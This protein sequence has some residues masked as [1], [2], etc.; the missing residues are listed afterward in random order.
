MSKINVENTEI[1]II[2]IEDKDYIS[3]TDMANAK[4]SESRASDIIKNWIRTRYALEFLSTWEQINNQHFKVVESDHFKMQAGLANFTLSISEWI[5]KTNAVGIIVK[6][7]KY[8][9]TF[10]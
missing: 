9:G 3:L 2:S 5:D 8:G 10:L 6:K 7:G 1:T 4:E